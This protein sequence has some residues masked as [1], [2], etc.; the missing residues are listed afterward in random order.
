[1]TYEVFY[2]LQRLK[3]MYPD[4][5]LS[6]LSPAQLNKLIAQEK[7][8]NYGNLTI[9]RADHPCHRTEHI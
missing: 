9:Y 4:M 5:N 2:N 6:S 8:E 1:M 7:E 3:T